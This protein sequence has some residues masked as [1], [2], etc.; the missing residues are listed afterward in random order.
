MSRNREEPQSAQEGNQEDNER[1]HDRD[2][3]VQPPPYYYVLDEDN[4][5]RRV[6]DVREWSEHLP[7]FLWISK[8]GE[9]T[10][11][12]IFHG[13]DIDY[14]C[15]DP[16]EELLFGTLILGGPLDGVE[17]LALT[18]EEARSTHEAAVE[19]VRAYRRLASISGPYGVTS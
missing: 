19:W 13:F 17:T 9:V 11:E 4:R 14:Y 16:D 12:T 8:V 10:V 2:G 1:D 3:H 6:D 15:D 5:P 18:Y 7:N